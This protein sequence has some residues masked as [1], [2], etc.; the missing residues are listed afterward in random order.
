MCEFIKFIEKD[1][2][3][4]NSNNSTKH[5]LDDELV[6][7]SFENLIKKPRTDFT[8]PDTI[9]ND[10]VNGSVN[11]GR[12]IYWIEVNKK[13]YQIDKQKLDES[14]PNTLL[15]KINK[16]DFNTK[17]DDK[18]NTLIYLD[19]LDYF[20]L[21]FDYLQGYSVENIQYIFNGYE[22][23]F[24]DNLECKQKIVILKNLLF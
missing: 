6:R 3:N 10:S 14:E 23:N 21:I 13:I 5:Y 24:D 2:T 7:T 12:L 11:A 16:V 19:K 18:T 4:N 8:K 20:D 1:N 9:T 22:N 17:F 15:L